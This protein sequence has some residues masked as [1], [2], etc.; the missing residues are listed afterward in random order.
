MGPQD[1]GNSRKGERS[2]CTVHLPQPLLVTMKRMSPFLV[3]PHQVQAESGVQA[4]PRGG[5]VA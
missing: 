4:E 2:D 3:L 5:G 1:N